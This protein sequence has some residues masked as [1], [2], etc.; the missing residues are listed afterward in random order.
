ML[1]I[2]MYSSERELLIE[3]RKGK[4]KAQKELYLLFAPKMLGVCVRYIYDKAEAEHVM[5]G[6]MVKVFEKL[7]QFSG[8]GSFEG[9]MR[10]IMVNESLMYLR[11]NKS[12]SLE[13]EVEEAQMEPDYESL[14]NQ[15]EVDD[16][17]KLIAE[18]PIGYR[19]VFNLYAIEG[20]SHKEISETLNIN[21]NTSKSQLSRAR[22]LLQKRLN[23]I[24]EI[25]I[26]KENGSVK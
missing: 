25:E 5:I 15:L 11:K 21:E 12:M 22:K 18:L 23:T 1:R 13:V 20:Y 10:R 16:L 8:E 9:W 26:K 4:Q 14:S 17:M 19:T 3:C 2:N 24:Q 7:E 6:G